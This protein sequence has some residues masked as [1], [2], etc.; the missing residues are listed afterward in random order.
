MKKI[1]LMALVALTIMS[2]SKEEYDNANL[3]GKSSLSVKIDMSQFTRSGDANITAAPELGSMLLV[4]TDKNGTYVTEK[5]VSQG[6]DAPTINVELIEKT[7]DAN[8]IG[9]K[10]TVYAVTIGNGWGTLTSV[11]P[12]VL[13]TLAAAQK[14]INLWQKD[15]AKGGFLN[16]P[17]YG[18]APIVQSGINADSHILLNAN[19]SITPELGRVQ[20][21]GTPTGEAK[22]VGT[23]V[24]TVSDVVVQ[25][26]F[27]NNV[28][29]NDILVSP[30]GNGVNDWADTNEFKAGGALF[31]MQDGGTGFGYQIFDGNK[32]HVI[33]KIT[34]NTSV[35]GAA[36]ASHTG[37]VTI[38]KFTY[39]SVTAGDLA[40]E[41]GK[42]Y[43]VDLGALAL[44]YDKIGD[45]PYD[46]TVYYDLVANVT[47]NKWT[48]IQVTPVLP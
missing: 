19:V 6:L 7:D 17:Y 13:P 44:T 5:L 40:V 20:V 34:Y 36:K 48:I 37:F 46:N 18:E 11:A 23:S 30:R 27:I 43:D 31:S 15:Q 39:G 14:D 16:V 10:V 21:K 45:E 35:D 42:I 4:V 8:L 32:P 22:T 47:V 41:K 2:C 3:A 29:S 28:V 26:V 12:Q 9:G 38:Q 1:L 33:V 24:I 25:S